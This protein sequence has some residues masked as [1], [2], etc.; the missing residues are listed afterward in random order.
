MSL[1]NI[2][3]ELEYSMRRIACQSKLNG[4]RGMCSNSL[5]SKTSST[6][7]T[8]ENRTMINLQLQEGVYFIAVLGVTHSYFTK[9][10]HNFY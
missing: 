1:L 2:L 5:K 7:L 4:D 8:L 3:Q 6:Y 9:T 10:K